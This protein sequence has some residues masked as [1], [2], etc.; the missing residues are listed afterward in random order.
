MRD[1]L[2]PADAASIVPT[3]NRMG[4]SSEVL[5]EISRAF[6][7]HAAACQEPVLDIGA[8]FG[9]AAIP[10]LERRATVYANDLAA[11]QLAELRRRTPAHL[12]PNLRL[13]PGRFPDELG[14]PYGSLAAVHASQVLHFL[15]PDLVVDGLAKAFR[16]LRPGGRLFVLA[17]TPYQG[18]H[19]GFIPAFRE[20]KARGE[21]WPGLMTDYKRW[22]THWSAALNPG[23]LHTFD[24][25]VLSAAVTAAG[26]VVDEVRMFRRAGL[27]DFCRLDGRENL[28][29]IAHRPD[30]GRWPD[31]GVPVTTPA[32]ATPVPL[33]ACNGPARPEAWE[34]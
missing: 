34:H 13:L 21:L 29:L 9:L 12:R 19:A 33:I 25:E 17:A 16:W 30:D 22:N 23:W 18:T 1:D 7:E 4:W 15:M 5:N 27:P 8:A 20:R 11:D 26:F 31:R 2:L 3:T 10:A 24:D 32:N 6:V 14:F 28:G